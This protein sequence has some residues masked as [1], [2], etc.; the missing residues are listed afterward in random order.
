MSCHK[1]LAAL[2]VHIQI[3]VHYSWYAVKLWAVLF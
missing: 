3:H 2:I 1:S